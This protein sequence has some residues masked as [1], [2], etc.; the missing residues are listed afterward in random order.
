MGGNITAE[1]YAGSITLGTSFMME[2]GVDAL[3]LPECDPETS[4]MIGSWAT[5]P[6]MMRFED[7]P[8]EEKIAQ[9][10]NVGIAGIVLAE[11]S[12]ALPGFHDTA[13]D[14]RSILHR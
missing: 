6:V 4:K 8:S 3:I 10:L 12:L 9:L 2:A 7:T 1:N 14:L 13:A 5:V 11:V